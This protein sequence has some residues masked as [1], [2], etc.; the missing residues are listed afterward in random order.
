MCKWQLG[1]R[2]TGERLSSRSSQ[3]HVN[4]IHILLLIFCPHYDPIKW[5]ESTHTYKIHWLCPLF[6]SSIFQKF[7]IYIWHKKDVVGGSHQKTQTRHWNQ[8]ACLLSWRALA[9]WSRLDPL[10][11]SFLQGSRWPPRRWE[12]FSVSQPTQFVFHWY[13]ICV[14]GSLL[15]C[16]PRS[17]MVR[18]REIDSE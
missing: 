17:E 6:H 13:I 2:S 7:H 8:K 12:Q 4:R 3:E 14:L 5:Y 11:S 1:V 16:A 18:W 10:L 9:R 15:R